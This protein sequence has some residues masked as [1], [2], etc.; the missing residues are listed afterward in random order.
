MPSYRK[1]TGR[2]RQAEAKVALAAF[3]T[4][5]QSFFAEQNSYTICVRQAITGLQ[6]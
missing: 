1:F 3:Y 4:A 6:P 5:E 2:A